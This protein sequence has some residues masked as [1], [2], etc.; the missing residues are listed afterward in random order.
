MS[1]LRYTVS[2]ALRLIEKKSTSAAALVEP[3]TQPPAGSACPGKVS[4]GSV[5][6]VGLPLRN[7]KCR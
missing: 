6:G 4:L 2:P 1:R 3:E 5:S 7:W